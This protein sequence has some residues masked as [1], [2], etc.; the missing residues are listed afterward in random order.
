MACGPV[1]LQSSGLADAAPAPV[2]SPSQLAG[3]LVEH[4]FHHTRTQHTC[5]STHHGW[6]L[7]QPAPHHRASK[8]HNHRP[9]QARPGQ[10]SQARHPL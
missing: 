1:L 9:G 10:A 6:E 8:G 5:P 2:P 7:L 4:A 3:P